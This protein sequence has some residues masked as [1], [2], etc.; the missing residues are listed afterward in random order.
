MDLTTQ[1]I[2]KMLELRDA[3]QYFNNLF[4]DTICDTIELSQNIGDERMHTRQHEL[5]TIISLKDNKNLD[6]DVA[7][8]NNYKTETTLFGKGIL[9][10][11]KNALNILKSTL[12]PNEIIVRITV[13]ITRET[14]LDLCGTKDKD[15]IK[16][17]Y[18]TITD[19]SKISTDEELIDYVCKK[20]NREVDVI[21]FFTMIGSPIFD[22]SIIT[23]Y[24]DKAFLIKNTNII[25]KAEQV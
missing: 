1:I 13:C 3:E 4:S 8:P 19:K 5:Y 16:R 18:N 14:L 9:C 22:G 10:Y 21:A 7:Q 24:M 17:V 20:G 15:Y 11:Q 23:D 25:V 2:K 12:E 6:L